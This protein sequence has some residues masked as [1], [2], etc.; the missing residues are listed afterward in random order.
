MNV[1][2]VFAPASAAK[3]KQPG[4]G[5]RRTFFKALLLVG[6]L[7]SGGLAGQPADASLL[8]TTTGTILSGS[9]TGGLFGLPGVATSL[10]GDS[11]T[12]IVRYSGLG[13]S[14]FTTGDG[15]FAQDTEDSP[16]TTG[17]VTAIVNG[18]SL[19][20]PLTNSL[21]SSLI[22]DLFSFFASNQGFN[23]A[24][25][26][27]AFVN[28]V[29]SLSCSDPCVP[30]ADLMHRF[31]YVLGSSD[32]GTDLYTFQGAG[33]PAPG[34]PTATFVGTETSFAFAVVP[35]PAPWVVMATGLFGLAML[36]RR[37]RA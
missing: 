25:N 19:T 30:Y 14:Y 29:Q 8:I 37:R 15:T 11:Y 6:A 20:S 12:L 26:V 23:G 32:I 31:S 16:G 33:F 18:V 17:S 2:S 13:P 21:G 22:E 24:S 5:A 9:E 3:P 4:D 36:G 35:E 7:L 10:S 34:T 28:V 27:G 1:L